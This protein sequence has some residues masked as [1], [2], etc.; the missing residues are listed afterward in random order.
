MN[1]QIFLTTFVLYIVAMVVFGWWVSR[2]KRGSGDD[3]LLGGRSVPL[4]LT[5]GTTVATMVGTGS[6]MGAV[7]F[8]YANGWA[9]ALYGLG[10]AVGILLLAVC[11]AP[12]RKF[13]FMTMSEELAYYVGANRLVRNVVALLIYIAC[14]GWLGAHISGGPFIFPGW[15]GLI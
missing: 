11:F 14:I 3:F 7:G 15:Q 6:S 13:R 1:S 8:G 9:G 5:V 12:V 10:G 4:F 2:H